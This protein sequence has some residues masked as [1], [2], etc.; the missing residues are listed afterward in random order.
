MARLSELL[1]LILA[2]KSKSKW[3]DSYFDIPGLVCKRNIAE[4][5]PSNET[6]SYERIHVVF[7]SH[8]LRR[9]PKNVLFFPALEIV[10]LWPSA[11]VRRSVAAIKMMHVS[12][13]Q[14]CRYARNSTCRQEAQNCVFC[15]THKRCPHSGFRWDPSSRL[16][17]K[18][19]ASNR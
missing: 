17:S 1:A 13:S 12:A 9:T 5:L 16:E 14:H 8:E 18:Y 2:F 15:R 19:E 3:S 7:R 10:R 4:V 6:Q 11:V